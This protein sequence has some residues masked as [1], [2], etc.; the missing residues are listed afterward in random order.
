MPIVLA[1]RSGVYGVRYP[2]RTRH[3]SRVL[4]LYALSMLY[5][6]I[7]REDKSMLLEILVVVQTLAIIGLVARVNRLQ[8]R[9]E[10]R[11]R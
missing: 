3:K 9:L 6:G 11:G 8:G 10:Y 4:D 7:S 1:R 2:T 5:L